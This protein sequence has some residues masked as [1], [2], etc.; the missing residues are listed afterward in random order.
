MPMYDLSFLQYFQ[1]EGGQSILYNKISR[2]ITVTDSANIQ[3]NI[4]LS[5]RVPTDFTLSDALKESVKEGDISY[6]VLINGAPH[7]NWL[8]PLE[9]TTIIKA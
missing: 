6:Y 7:K 4:Y 9:L 8:Y 1:A 3:I 2:C 5:K